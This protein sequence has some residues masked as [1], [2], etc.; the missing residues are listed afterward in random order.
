MKILKVL[1]LII[2]GLN[3]SVFAQQSPAGNLKIVFI[4]HGEKPKKGDNLTCQG[5]NRA[6]LLPKLLKDRFGIPDSIFVPALV[7]GESTGHSRMF[8]TIAP[9]AIKYNLPINTSHGE[10]DS[11][12]IA[13]DLKSKNGTIFLVWEHKAIAPI[14]RSLGVNAPRLKWPD[15]DY[16]SI[17]IVTFKNGAAVLT[18]EKEGLKPAADCKF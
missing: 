12:L 18:K 4:R 1:L 11:V 10:K 8:Q 7:M 5:L 3:I 15:D 17:W 9:F 6:L 13:N 14:V 2:W 16:D